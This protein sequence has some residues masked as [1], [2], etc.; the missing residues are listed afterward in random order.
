MRNLGGVEPPLARRR[1]AQVLDKLAENEI[2]GAEDDVDIMYVHLETDQ[3]ALRERAY[4]QAIG[5]AR[6]RAA[7]LARL[8]D[9]K[10]GKMTIVREA[11]YGS[12]AD[13]A[14]FIQ[15]YYNFVYPSSTNGWK[16]ATIV[17]LDVDLVVSF[18]LE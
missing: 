8:S 12:N 16:V 7:L 11:G 14:E 3:D 1:V 10:L 18:E 5:D 17:K 13:Q 4:A 9:R 2:T 6:K 15:S